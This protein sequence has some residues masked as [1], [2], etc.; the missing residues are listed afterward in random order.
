MSRALPGVQS[1]DEYLTSVEEAYTHDAYHSLSIEG[2]MVSEDLINRV[3]SGGWNPD[4]NATDATKKNALACR[5]Y[6]ECFTK[7]K[8]NVKEGLE[9]TKA[10]VVARRN[11]GAWYRAL[12]APHVRSGILNAVALAGYRNH[13]VFIKG[14][15]HVP[16]NE[17]S[18]S[19]AMSTMFDRLESEDS[20]I[21]SAI[22]GHWMLGYIHP[23]ADGNGR[24]AKFLMNLM[25]SSGGYPW[26]TIKVDN[27]NKYMAALESASV[28]NDIQPFAK[29]I[30][31][32]VLAEE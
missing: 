17:R 12:F 3:D 2:Y 14:S 23:Y 27:R 10:G 30:A 20:P 16:V 6:L 25:L 1:I 9:G 21:V 29:F 4:E 22:L 31:H 18:V 8:N 7:V 15:R 13:P 11:H 19:D 26:T 5:G 32:A 24:M 28:S